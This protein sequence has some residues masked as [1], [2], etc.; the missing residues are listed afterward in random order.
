MR[1]FDEHSAAAVIDRM[2]GCKDPRLRQIM[3]SLV[4]HLHAA[5]R[6]VEPTMQE[7]MSA[8]QF[9]TV[10]GQKCDDKRQE[11][12]LLSDVLG[13]SMLID[14]INHRKPSGAS[15]STVLGPFFVPG[16]PEMRMGDSISR[17]GKRPR[18]SSSS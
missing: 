7:W 9:L 8:V 15:E 4:T 5:L 17:D 11:F 1:N 2:S 14:A 16:A 18:S 6:E 10:V 3:T 12:I 13:V